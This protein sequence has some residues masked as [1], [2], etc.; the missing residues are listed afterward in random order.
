M[1]LS[2]LNFLFLGIGNIFWVPLAIKFGKRASM[3]SSMLFQAGAFM[4]CAV[5]T[6]YDSLL[7]ARCVLGF[8]AASGEVRTESIPL[9]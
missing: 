2:Q 1:L 3:T 6:R 7:A 8:A 5:A 4:W 9:A